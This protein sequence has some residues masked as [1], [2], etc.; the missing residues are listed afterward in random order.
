MS[1]NPNDNCLAGMRCPNPGCGSYG[2]F[3]VW[4]TVPVLMHDDGSE[5]VHGDMEWESDTDTHCPKCGK[6][7]VWSDFEERV[8][9]AEAERDAMAQAQRRIREIGE[10]DPPLSREEYNKA[11]NEAIQDFAQGMLYKI[12]ALGNPVQNSLLAGLP[13][14]D[15]DPATSDEE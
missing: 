9:Q 14:A 1:E 2:P 4:A 11:M 3:R 5:D 8:Q 7:G 13:W 12:R 15:K 6:W 10:A